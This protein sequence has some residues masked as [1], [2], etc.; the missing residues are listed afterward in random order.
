MLTQNVSALTGA[1]MMVKRSKYLE[2]GG[3]DAINLP[4]SL[5]DVD[6]C[7]RLME[8]RYWNVFTPYCEAIHAESVSRGFD[9]DLGKLAR[10]EEE[11]G[12]F[13]RRHQ[14]I[15]SQGDPFYNPNLSLNDEDIRYRNLPHL[16]EEKK[17]GCFSQKSE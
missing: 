14:K 1:L 5:N 8:K 11:I 12:Y 3:L 2:V 13:A 15:L 7:L 4:V 17:I 16:G 10:F 9:T 6:F